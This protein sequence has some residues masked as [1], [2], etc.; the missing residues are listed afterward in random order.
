M[1]YEEKEYYAFYP[2]CVIKYQGALPNINRLSIDK[3]MLLKEITYNA[4]GR[5]PV[6][7]HSQGVKINNL[8]SGAYIKWK[9]L[10]GTLEGQIDTAPDFKLITEK[11]QKRNS[12]ATE[13]ATPAGVDTIYILP[14]DEYDGANCNNRV[15]AEV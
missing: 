5:N 15:V 13:I 3:E 9:A 6:Y 7:N 12:A 11:N 14:N 10:G 8:S 2:L 1:K 4:D